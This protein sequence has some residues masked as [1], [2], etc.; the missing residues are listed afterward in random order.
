MRRLRSTLT[1]TTSLALVS[2]SSQAPRFGI[3]FAAVRRRPV[4]GSFS[5]VKYAPGERTSC[6]T[7]T[8]SAPLIRNV[9]CLVI[10]GTS[11]IKSV[12]SLTSPVSFTRSSTDTRSGAA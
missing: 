6:D 10:M 2:N 9:P 8:R 7:T 4:A 1:D 3:S 11:P 12:C 5:A